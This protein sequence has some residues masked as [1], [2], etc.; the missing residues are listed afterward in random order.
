LIAGRTCTSGRANEYRLVGDIV[1]KG[2][3]LDMWEFP[4]GKQLL[5]SPEIYHVEPRQ[6]A[7][8][9]QPSVNWT[10]YQKG[11]YYL[12]VKVFN[13]LPPC[14]EIESHNPKKLKFI[15]KKFLY[16]NTF[17]SLDEY[18]EFQNLTSFLYVIN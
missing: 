7:N 13:K 10:K 2:P 15:L 14:T 12:G 17:Y 3:F 16:E 18:F 1:W 5:V 6:H 11:E 9:H 8:F 4:H